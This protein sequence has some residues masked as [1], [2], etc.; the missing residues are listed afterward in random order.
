M[1]EGAILTIN[2]GS[3][4]VKFALFPAD[5]KATLRGEVTKTPEGPRMTARDGAGAALPAPDL[6]PAADAIDI[7]MATAAGRVGPSGLA[8]VGHRMVHGGADHFAPERVTPDLLAA[9]EALTPLDP[10]H[11]PRGLAQMRAVAA[12]APALA[13]VACFDTAFHHTLP[14]VATRLGLPRAVS[15]EG[16]R[17]YGFHGLSYEWI[18][19]R[20]AVEHPDLSRVVVAHLGSGATLCAL[21]GG[22]SVETTAGFSALDGLMMA[23]RCGALDPGAVLHLLR[24]GRSVAEVEVMLYH[25]SGL[26]GVSGISGDVRVLLA[27]ADPAA[28][29]ALALFTYRIAQGVA[30]MAGAMGGLDALVFTAGIGAR[31]PAIRAAVCD[32]LKWLGARLSPSAN[33]ANAASIGASGGDIALLVMETDEEAMIA[34]HTA[35]LL[36]TA[37]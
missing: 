27:S 10:L 22:V 37:E 15:A 3:S 1:T 31:S 36:R 26:L 5:L 11:M 20:L 17:R 23:T 32:R 34:R 24:A 8:A 35:A 16:L 18:A 12:R 4:G 2:A 9:L 14:A 29:E 13:Q 28:A 6:D 19:G 33:A 30:E 25:G 7:V 21:H